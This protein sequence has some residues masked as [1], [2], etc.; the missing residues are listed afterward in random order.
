MVGAVSDR[1][2]VDTEVPAPAER[3]PETK[4]ERTRRRL[5]AI[6][7]ERFGERG[8]RATSVSEIA[9]AAGLT[10]AAAYAYFPSK[11]ALFDAAVDADAS[12]LVAEAEARVEGTPARQLVPMLL[13]MFLGGLD[14]HPL[15]R[16][17]LSGQEPDALERLVDLPVLG[18]LTG[19]ISD[20]IRAAQ[21]RGEVRADIDADLFASGAETIVLSLLMSIT[22]VGSSTETRR[23]LGVLTIFDAVLRPPE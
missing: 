14:R 7:I 9:R 23:Q 8:Y 20:A 13:V 11:E 1:G 3:A 19:D 6:A 15:V 4:G 10:Q 12:A 22:Q 16:R 18:R 5:L 17:V 2:A 21:E